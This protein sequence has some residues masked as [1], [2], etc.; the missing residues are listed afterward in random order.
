MYEAP[1]PVFI[2]DYQFEKYLNL[3]EG[4]AV[5]EKYSKADVELYE[6]FDNTDY[7]EIAAEIGRNAGLANL[8]AHP[9]RMNPSSP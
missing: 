5:V 1:D 7:D 3:K 2:Q 6:N 8:I 9:E 4:D